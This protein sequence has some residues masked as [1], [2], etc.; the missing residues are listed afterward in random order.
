MALEAVKVLVFCL[1]SAGAADSSVTIVTFDG[2]TGKTFDFIEDEDPVMGSESW[3]NWTVNATEKCGSLSGV[4]TIVHRPAV[5]IV[6]AS[7]GFI[8]AGAQAAY[9]NVS[10]MAGGAFV[11]EVR[12]LSS[13]STF[14]FSF[15][16]G[17]HVP[18]Y[19]CNGGGHP[20]FSRGCYKAKFTIPSGSDF[21]QVRLPLADFSDR[22]TP[23]TGNTFK[24][25]EED[26]STCVTAKQLGAIQLL[27]VWAE[28]E[29]GPVHL[30][31]RSISIEGPSHKDS[32]DVLV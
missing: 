23:A 30:D 24:T 28:G 6:G 26:S 21:S 17:A 31:V 3:G 16:S 4:V 19:S 22:W 15:A 14:H 29:T 1:F 13:Y 10:A 12:S 2:S 27:Q 25:C 8:K 18:K 5:S 20:P 11:L 9:P 7:P 32:T